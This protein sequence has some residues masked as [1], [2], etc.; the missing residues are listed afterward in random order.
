MAES[1]YEIKFDIIGFSECVSRGMEDEF[2]VLPDGHA[3]YYRCL[4]WEKDHSYF[5][6]TR[7]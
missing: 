4:K 5:L 3:L 7:I 2:I 6:S 1:Y